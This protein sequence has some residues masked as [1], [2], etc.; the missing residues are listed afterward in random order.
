[1]GGSRPTFKYK[2]AADTERTPRKQP[3]TRQ[4][5]GLDRAVDLDRRT[6]D[7]GGDDDPGS[8]NDDPDPGDD[9]DPE[10]I[11]YCYNY[12]YPWWCC[13]WCHCWSPVFWDYCGYDSDYWWGYWN[14]RPNTVFVEYYQDYDLES[15]SPSIYTP[16]A[17]AVDATSLA[18]QYLDEGA[19]F[20]RAGK[21]LEALRR[22]RLATLADLDFAIPKFAYAHALFALGLYDSAAY[23]I[24]KGLELMPEW[25]DIGGDLKLM[26]DTPGDFDAQLQALIDH[27][28]LWKDDETALLTLGYVTYFTGD[29]Y[30]AD[31]AFARLGRSG[32][33]ANVLVAEHFRAAIGRIKEILVA[34]GRSADFM[35]DDGLTIDDILR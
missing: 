35:T 2:P 7:P 25:T 3:R 8:G 15:F 30:T 22:F 6:D 26:Y 24:T 29:L 10:V 18:I 14:R 19:E 16:P 21:Y 1:M 32:I 9:D 28:R 11:V 27:L 34:E 33:P 4:S 17:L 20:F 12:W 23:E 5:P 13:S 31:K